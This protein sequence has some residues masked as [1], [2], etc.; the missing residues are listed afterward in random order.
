MPICALSPIDASILFEKVYKSCL[1]TFV[2][3][4]TYVDLIILEMVDFDV[5]L[6][7]NVSADVPKTA[8]RMMYGHFEL[9]KDLNLMQKRWMELLED[10]DVT[11]LY[12]RKKANVV[13][14]A[15]SRKAGSMGILV[16]FQVSICPL[17]IEV[18]T[19]AY[20]LMRLEFDDEKLSQIPDVI[21]QRE[22]KEVVSDEIGVLNI[23]GRQLKHEYHRPGGLLQRMSIPEWKCEG[24][25]WTF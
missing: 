19:L 23:K 8:F 20:E 5:I 3:R 12:H 15:M 2:G 7:E 11:I 24:L 1:V 14:D 6:D 9:L 13:D 16:H 21:L 25:Q 18:K 10:Y 22:A 17:A 4:K